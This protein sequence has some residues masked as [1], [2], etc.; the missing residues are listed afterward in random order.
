MP[1]KPCL[2]VLFNINFLQNIK[3]SKKIIYVSQNIKNCKNDHK[4]SNIS[5]YL[6]TQKLLYFNVSKSIELTEII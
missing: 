6:L 1:N 3:I 5:K 2:N 4:Y